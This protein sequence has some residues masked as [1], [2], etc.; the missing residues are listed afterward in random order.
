MPDVMTKCYIHILTW[1]AEAVTL[2]VNVG[3][4][5]IMLELPKIKAEADSLEFRPE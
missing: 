1:F 5:I 4:A 2:S 3:T